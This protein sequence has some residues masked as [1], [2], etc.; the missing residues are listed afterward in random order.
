M[1]EGGSLEPLIVYWPGV[2][3]VGK[4][5][6]DLI[7]AVDFVPTFAE[8]AGA[9]L[10][11]DKIIDGQSFNAQIHGQKGNPRSSIFVQLA[12]NYYVRN[13]GWKLNQSGELF[14]MSKAPFE[15]IPVPSDTKNPDAV[16]ARK[17]L[18]T[19]LDQLN[20]AGGYVDTGD[21]TGRHVGKIRKVKK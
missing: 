7:S 20:P 3:P 16:A 1:L 8:I 18:Q 10:P 19:D 13:S 9:D 17:S 4:I 11:K 15:E 5:S 21:G 2:T 6:H 14:D 12:N